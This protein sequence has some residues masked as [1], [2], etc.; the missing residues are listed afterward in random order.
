MKPNYFLYFTDEPDKE[1]Y[2]LT[3]TQKGKDDRLHLAP[4]P[5]KSSTNQSWGWGMATDNG[6]QYCPLLKSTVITIFP[7]DF[8]HPT[9]TRDVKAIR[10]WAMLEKEET[11]QGL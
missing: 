2:R 5:K 4:Y 3:S 6:E 10:M 1:I 8:L 7:L 9:T 11:K